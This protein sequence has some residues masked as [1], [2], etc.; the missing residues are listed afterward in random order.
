MEWKERRR[1][2][3][4]AMIVVS[5]GIMLHV[6]GRVWIDRLKFVAIAAGRLLIARYRTT[7]DPPP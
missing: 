5:V 4:V 3:I 1:L 6:A 2:G 7:D